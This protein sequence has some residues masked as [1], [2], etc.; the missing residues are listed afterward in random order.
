MRGRSGKPGRVREPP[1][2]GKNRGSTTKSLNR[3]APPSATEH[4]PVCPSPPSPVPPSVHA[5]PSLLLAPSLPSS[6][7][8]RRFSPSRSLSR[9]LAPAPV[10]FSLC[11]S[12]LSS[13]LSCPSSAAAWSL[14][15]SLSSRDSLCHFALRRFHGQFVSDSCLRGRR[16]TCVSLGPRRRDLNPPGG[17]APAVHADRQS[18][19]VRGTRTYAR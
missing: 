12:L 14:P 10:S 18:T 16:V 5:C 3:F 7:F 17:Y 6:F 11:L 9:E 8:P 4:G 1:D 15:L 13:S 2:E 19:C